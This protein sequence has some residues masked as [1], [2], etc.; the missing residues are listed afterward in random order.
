MYENEH[1]QELC[2]YFYC[3]IFVVFD[4][5]K[6]SFLRYMVG[7]KTVL[8]YFDNN[9]IRWNAAILKSLF[10]LQKLKKILQDSL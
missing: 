7:W 8:S 10:G 2:E 9:S 5:E 4:E 6:E 1:Y 3:E